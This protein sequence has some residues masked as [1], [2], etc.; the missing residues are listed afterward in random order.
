M[1]S[2]VKVKIVVIL[3][4]HLYTGVQLSVVFSQSFCAR[5]LLHLFGVS[6]HACEA[7]AL[8][9]KLEFAESPPYEALRHLA[10]KAFDREVRQGNSPYLLIDGNNLSGR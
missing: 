10:R 6:Y 3:N 7:F 4:G 1:V 8:V 5:F 9:R 2:W